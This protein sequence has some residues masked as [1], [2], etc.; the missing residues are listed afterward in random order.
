ML[1]FNQFLRPILNLVFC[2]FYR[3]LLILMFPKHSSVFKRLTEDATVS[4]IT[5]KICQGNLPK[6]TD[7]KRSAKG[8]MKSSFDNAPYTTPSSSRTTPKM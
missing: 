4:K 2:A 6:V 3:L 7:L 8:A 1:C 5:V